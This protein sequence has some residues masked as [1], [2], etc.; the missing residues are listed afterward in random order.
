MKDGL[1]LR[2]EPS[3]SGGDDTVILEIP[4]GATVDVIDFNNDCSWAKV[5][6]G[7]ETGWVSAKNIKYIG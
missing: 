3:V 4:Y 5:Q 6:Y 1:N 7:G 2:T